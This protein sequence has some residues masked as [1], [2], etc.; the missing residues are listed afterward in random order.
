MT[1]IRLT[2]NT[3][4]G[5]QKTQQ[6]FLSNTIDYYFL[7]FAINVI[8][9]VFNWNQMHEYSGVGVFYVTF[10]FYVMNYYSI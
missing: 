7:L 5:G 8:L 6:F 3:T 10:I 4:I 1:K 9:M 2:T